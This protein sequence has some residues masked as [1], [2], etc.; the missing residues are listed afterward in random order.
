[1]QPKTKTKN[2]P[3]QTFSPQDFLKESGHFC[4]AKS[5]G[6]HAAVYLSDLF[7]VIYSVMQQ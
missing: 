3:L 1:M 2:I 7:M 4:T 6:K 5:E